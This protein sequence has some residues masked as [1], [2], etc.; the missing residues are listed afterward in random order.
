M[1][2]KGFRYPATRFMGWVMAGWQ[3]D[4]KK[5]AIFGLLE[6]MAWRNAF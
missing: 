3:Q 2:V 5:E 1:R 6:G 4:E